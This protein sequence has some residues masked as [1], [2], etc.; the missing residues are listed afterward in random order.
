MELAAGRNDTWLLV[1]Q[2]TPVP[3]WCVRPGT[4]RVAHPYDRTLHASTGANE[5]QEHKSSNRALK[6]RRVGAQALPEGNDANKAEQGIV[7]W[8]KSEWLG[9]LD[10]EGVT[11]LFQSMAPDYFYGTCVY[12]PA[13]EGV[14]LDFV[15][16]QPMLKM[17][18]SGFH[19]TSASAEVGEDYEPF[20]MLQ[21]SPSCEQDKLL[22]LDLGDIYETLV[23]NNSSDA[24]VVSMASDGSPLYLIPPR[25]G[26]VISD[27][28]Q[29]HR[30]KDIAQKHSGFDMIVMDPPWQNASVDRMSHYG[31]MDLYDLFKI[32]ILHLL[33]KDGVVAVWI[34]N[35]AKVQ[36]VVVEKLFPAW[37]LTWVAHWFWLKVTTHGEPVL[38]L[39]C[40]HRKPYEGI[41]IG[42]RI[43]SNNTDTST[44]TAGLPNVN[45]NCSSSHSV[46][47]KLLVSVPSQ[48]SR[49][50]S[51]A[52]LLEKEFL[53]SS[54]ENSNQ[55]KEPR[56]LELFARNLEE[57]FVSWGNEPIRYQYCGRGPANGT[58]DIQDG[59]LVPAPRPFVD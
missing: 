47:K 19:N 11:L 20:G 26:F 28:S 6:K 40:G 3:S 15:Q 33:S 22:A 34:T 51:I 7:A 8:I 58:L 17:L 35:R 53:A 55:D 31:T 13:D 57:G 43:P 54:E 5:R 39:E 24:M 12:A 32:P 41:L 29:I 1:P 18:T 50:P 46:K 45:K 42:T 48:H 59:F 9:L 38:S 27:F 14:A 56:R 23:T 36:K 4:F 21:L 44:A 52:Q 25:S 10:Q 37:G 2:R 49:K 30:L 16:L